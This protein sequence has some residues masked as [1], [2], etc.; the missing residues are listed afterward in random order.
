MK[1]LITG[2]AGF[3]GSHLAEGHLRSGDEV[4][5]VDN[6]NDAYDPAVKHNN[7]ESAKRAG[8]EL[9]VFPIDIRDRQNLAQAFSR[10]IDCVIHLAA[11]AGVRPSIEQPD[12]YYDV[13]V[14]GTLKLLE[15]C[16]AFDIRKFVFASS[17]SVYGNNEKVP[18]SETDP[19]DNPISPY[20]ATKKAGELLC[21]TYHSLYGFDMACLR[22][23]TV[24]GPRQRPDLAIH[25][26][27][28]L[29]TE[30]RPI[31]FFGDGTS[32]R[33]YTYIDDIIDGVS[34]VA[35]WVMQGDGRYEI[36]NLG[37]SR[38][39]T[40]DEMAAAI[41][42]ALGKKALLRR[43][44]NQPGDVT[45]TYADITKSKALLGYNPTMDFAQG[46]ARFI[47]WYRK[48]GG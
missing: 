43:Q 40:L 21:Y 5:I 6:F 42:Q 16:R 10:D 31:P 34:K 8:G 27:T 48:Q 41:E 7:I 37:E 46:I 24:Y 33:D 20:A 28:K 35:D 13:N 22:F 38:T 36:F 32:S 44:P 11:M 19:V 23:F 2:G 9:T 30:G 18:F 39:V 1:V 3:I 29:I 26:F 25:K 17:S 15:L 45:I 14:M 47:D 12:L 4:I